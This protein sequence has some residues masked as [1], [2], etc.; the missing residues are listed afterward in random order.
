MLLSK[1][2]NP[3]VNTDWPVINCMHIPHFLSLHNLVAL[4]EFE[5]EVLLFVTQ[6]LSFLVPPD[7]A[8]LPVEQ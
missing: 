8:W 6:G 2:P 7:P 1:T 5:C 4:F 3:A